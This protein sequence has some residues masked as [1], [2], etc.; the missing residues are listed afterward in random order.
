MST[1]NDLA[2]KTVLV[3]GASG[4]L[5]S[6]T[7][8]VL[9]E[10]GCFVH[11]L[12]RRTS[13]T[14]QLRL[15][16]VTIFFGDVAAA[17]SLATAFE[18]VEY[19]VHAAADTRGS[20]EEGNSSTVHGTKNVLALCERYKVR[21][22]VYIS[23]CNVYGV[24]DYRQGQIVTEESALERFPEKRGPYSHAKLEAEQLITRAMM[25]GNVPIVCLRPG[26]IYG[27]GGAIYTQ[28]I[29]FSL[30]RKFFAV[31]DDNRFVLPL[32]YVDN[33]VEA[34]MLVMKKLD[35]VSKIYNV[36][37]PQKVTKRDYMEGLVKKL[38]PRSRTVYIPFS[39]FKVIVFLQEKLF[40]VLKRSPLLTMYRLIS[41]QKP[42]VYDVSKISNDLAW[43][44]PVAVETAYRNLI[45]FEKERN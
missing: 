29:G 22:L 21:K 2:G 43:Q 3:T 11:A 45:E 20:E 38:Y 16:N 42:V 7:V 13:R 44:P 33:L 8:A 41:S 15:P 14:E 26:T 23:T 25:V 17:E 28:M 27:P 1:A 32:V 19:V 35:C 18:G 30:G 34:I 31:I 10:Q 12:V 6:R 39:L 4:F 24:A 5:G 9:S 40:E 37:D 36:V